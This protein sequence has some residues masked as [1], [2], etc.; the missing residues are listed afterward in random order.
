MSKTLKSLLSESKL[1]LDGTSSSPSLDAEVLICHALNIAKKD[2][3]LQADQNLTAKKI[4]KIEDLIHRRKNG[5]PIA[6]ILK[7]KEFYGL[8]FIVSPAVLIPR[9][10]SE[11]LIETALDK[12]Q[13]AARKKQLENCKTCFTLRVLDLGTGSGC[14]G[15]SLINESKKLSPVFC[16]LLSEYCAS[17][18]SPVALNVA[19]KN[20]K[21]HQ[22]KNIKF[23][24][25]DLF[26]NR[27]L[28]KKFDLIIANLPYVPKDLKTMDEL[29]YEPSGAIFADDNGSD[30]I[31]KFLDQVPNYLSNNS[32][33]LIELDPRNAQ[34]VQRYAKKIFKNVELTKDLAGLDRYL[35]I[36]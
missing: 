18:V 4:A 29:R 8:N 22:I 21:I 11:W 14:L 28:H 27:F 32:T 7:Q 9:P 26:S 13:Q 36:S 20:A 30:I 17:D 12:I 33:I 25:S 23:I 2:L 24:H 3:I 34:E 19:R 31:K 15:I 1:Q 5:E 16:N 10:E 6:Y 35:T